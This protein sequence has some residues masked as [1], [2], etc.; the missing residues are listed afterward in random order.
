MLTFISR[1]PTGLHYLLLFSAAFLLR[2]FTFA[3]IICPGERYIQADSMDYHNCATLI[4][5]ANSFTNPGTQEPIFWRTPGYP[6]LLAPF[7]KWLGAPTSNLEPHRT[8]HQWILWI[9]ILLC[10]LIPIIL[11]LLAWQLTG[12]W[13][14]AWVTSIISVVHVG[15][16]LATTYLLTDALASLF[17]YLFLLLITRL[18]F[19]AGA[20]D[21]SGTSFKKPWMIAVLGSA[22]MLA[23]YTWMRPNGKFLAL[24][25]AMLMTCLP[26][27][28]IFSRIK[29]SSIFLFFFFLLLSPWYLRNYELTGKLFFCPMS[30]AYLNSFCV[31]KIIRRLEGGTYLDAH[32][33]A[34]YAIAYET[35]EQQQLAKATENTKCISPYLIGTALAIP[36][37]KNY[38]HYFIYDWL[39]QVVKTTFD[40]FS[41]QLAA[42]ALNCYRY[43][44]LEEFITEK[45]STTLFGPI[46]LWMK[47][48]GWIELLFYILIWFG[49]CAGLYH[50]VF[51]ALW[52]YW[53]H[54]TPLTPMTILWIFCIVLFG[55]FVVQTGGFGYARLRIPVEPLLLIASLTY[56]LKNTLPK[57]MFAKEHH[58]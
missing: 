17:F 20:F 39:V 2:A 25:V 19:H 55:G 51:V 41:Y 50:Y 56:L 11:L 28:H 58:G 10:S 42:L 52:N 47:L 45:W 57:T 30:G 32:R 16:I 1:K 8:A 7:Y 44:P 24:L 29:K 18:W 22:F 27:L 48:I 38:P 12:S 14:I 40:L 31:P 4:A 35:Y 9:Q 54:K 13:A 6:A 43:D 53:Q 26:A 33:K 23:I 46:P 34:H 15:F 37:L 5:Y 36:Y 49:V 3:F 21:W